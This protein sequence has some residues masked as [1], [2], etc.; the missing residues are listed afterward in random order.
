M[1]FLQAVVTFCHLDKSISVTLLHIC[2]VAF[3]YSPPCDTPYAY[4]S[5]AVMNMRNTLFMPTAA[6]Q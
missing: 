4:S 1:Q 6:E 5:R 2:P 3:S